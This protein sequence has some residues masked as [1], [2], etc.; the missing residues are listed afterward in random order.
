MVPQ[1]GLPED[2]RDLLLAEPGLVLEDDEVMQAIVAAHDTA[3]G[4]NVIDLRQIAI[5]RLEARLA[6][7]NDT[8]RTVIAAAYDNVAG[9]NM[10]HR[11]VL[12]LVQCASL[13]E[14][15]AAIAGPLPGILRLESVR[16]VLETDDPAALVCEGVQAVRPGFVAEYIGDSR[17]DVVLRAAPPMAT[18][19]HAGAAVTSEA[20]MRLDLGPGGGRAMLALGAADPEQFQPGQGTDLLAFLAG[21]TGRLLT[22]LVV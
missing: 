22:R 3:L 20:L 1:T 16:L 4:A 15:C 21:V 14:V 6:R 10:I 2:L 12:A 9:T 17:R 8:H 5:D 7:L 18:I 11:A 13:T 19:V